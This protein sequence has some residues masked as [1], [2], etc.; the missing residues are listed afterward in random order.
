MTITARSSAL[1][2]PSTGDWHQWWE[3]EARTNGSDWK[4]LIELHCQILGRL[5]ASSSWWRP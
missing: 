5:Q 4:S 2:A 1:T 3:V